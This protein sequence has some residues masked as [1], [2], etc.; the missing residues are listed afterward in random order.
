MRPGDAEMAE[1]GARWRTLLPRWVHSDNETCPPRLTGSLRFCWT[2]GAVE[3]LAVDAGKTPALADRIA[4]QFFPALIPGVSLVI[5]QDFLHRV[6]PWLVVQMARLS[7]CF[8]P[9]Q[10][11]SSDC[12]VFLCTA[13]VTP[14]DLHGARTDG[15]KDA[16]LIAGLRQAADLFAPS[17]PRDRFRDM[18]K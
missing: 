3:V 13:P 12:V 11:V 16:A 15:L 6:Q 8:V 7:H 18:V 9:L 10:K 1:C 5:Q 14:A 4:E 17:L 2:G